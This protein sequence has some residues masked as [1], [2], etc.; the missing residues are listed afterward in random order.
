MIINS[1]DLNIYYL[2]TGRA[3]ERQ[4]HLS[5]ILKGRKVTEVRP[6]ELT[7]DPRSSGSLGHARL[8]EV[9]LSHQRRNMPFQ[10]F[11]ILE[12]DVA[13]NREMPAFFDIPDDSDFCYL[14]ISQLGMIKGKFQQKIIASEIDEDLVRIYN[15]LSMHAILICSFRG[16]AMYQ[17][18]MSDGYH[19][20]RMWDTYM[21]QIQPWVNAYA[22]KNPIFYQTE[23][24]G[25]KQNATK[26]KLTE[27]G[28][29]LQLTLEGGDKFCSGAAYKCAAAVEPS[30]DFLQHLNP[31]PQKV[32][33][34]WS[35]KD[36]IKSQNPL[37]LNG[38]KNLMDINPDWE[39]Q[40][41]TDKEVE[42]YLKSNLSPLDYT[43]LKEAPMVPKVD[44]W[45]LLKIYLE[46]GLYID[47]DRYC[48]K[49]LSSLLTQDTKCILPLHRPGD[50][51]VDFSQDIMLSSPRNPMH[52][53]ALELNLR[54]RRS[55]WND[56]M[57]LAP[58]TYFHALTKFIYGIQVDRYP[59]QE[60]VDDII[61][62]ITESPYVDFFIE[63]PP[64]ETLLFS[65]DSSTWKEGDGKGK[66]E[67]YK[68][69]K[70][71]H[72]TVENPNIREN[73]QFN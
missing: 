3:P 55:G 11:L 36:A 49:E 18:C 42:N 20:H 15:M 43:L 29:P 19:H 58:I 44:V 30:L 59:P 1:Q 45:R 35:T 54:R 17:K 70:V 16:A 24:L 46:G 9:G 5:K 28:S 2:T 21:A 56:I 57:T 14:G 7:D 50:K 52:R 4:A 31:I 51:I 61:N 33:V 12:D 63:K 25:G 73:R 37:M 67:F 48:N 10:P 23:E 71:N 72:W 41:S 6:F 47:I 39:V 68:E 32:H 34:S 53:F 40:I 13:F 38:L 8:I 64:Y 69:S 26:F 22:F 66:E 27:F 60:V 62:A 65:F